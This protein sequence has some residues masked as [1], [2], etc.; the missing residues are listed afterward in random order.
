MPRAGRQ[1]DA[2]AVYAETRRLPVDELGLEPGTALRR[3]HEDIL[4]GRDL[5]PVPSAVPC[6]SGRPARARGLDHDNKLAR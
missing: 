5:D 3:L 4:H 6:C 2:L 1:A